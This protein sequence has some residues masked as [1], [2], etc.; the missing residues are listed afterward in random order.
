MTDE[1]GIIRSMFAAYRARDRVSV[2]NTFTD[3]FR[4]TSPYDDRIDKTAYFERC[5]PASI[6]GWLKDQDIERIVVDGDAAFVT[7]RC[8]TT[9]DKSFR[10]TEF[11]TFDGDRI[12]SI[13]VYF[14]AAYRNGVFE[15]QQ[16]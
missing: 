3:D 5:W 15:Q 10:N 4:F 7:Y 9:D 16:A 13:D 12:R 8:V 11:I 6:S 1:A 14:G 2:E